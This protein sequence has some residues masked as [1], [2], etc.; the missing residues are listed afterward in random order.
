MPK[1]MGTLGGRERKAKRGQAGLSL[2]ALAI[3]AVIAIGA[4]MDVELIREWVA[5]Q[6]SWAPVAFVMI[7][8]T[9]AALC[10]PMDLMAFVAGLLFDFAFGLLLIASASY[11]GQCL[12]YLFARWLF[13]DH[14]AR[15]LEA[16]PRLRIV[17]RA[18]ELRGALLL[19]LTR[20][21]P[22]PAG[23][24]SYLVGASRMPFGSFALAN[25][26]LIPVS[27]ISLLIARGLLQAGSEGQV[28]GWL[29]VGAGLAIAGLSAAGYVVRR[30][31]R[32]DGLSAPG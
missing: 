23:P 13:P 27:F 19:F 2:L 14:F 29:F 5:A 10:V 11:L 16:R 3:G 8:M 22:I 21:A 1:L 18:I 32:S 31:M 20:L 6:G 4:K 9:L 28:D 25:L 15:F 26:G 12:A 17:E 7:G 24:M 30:L